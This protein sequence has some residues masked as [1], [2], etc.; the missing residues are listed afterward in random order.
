MSGISGCKN[1]GP[2]GPVGGAFELGQSLSVGRGRDA[3]IFGNSTG[4]TFFAVVVNSGLD[5]V[6]QA[7]FTLRASGIRAPDIPPLDRIPLPAEEGRAVPLRPDRAFESRLRDVERA[8][9]T[10]RFAAT[11]QWNATRVPALP[12][13]V[14]IGDLVTVNVNATDPCANPQYHTARVVAIGAKA[15]ILNDTLNPKP[16]F[17]T[18]DFQRYAAKFDTLVYP[19]DVDAFGEPTDI[20]KNGH[21]AIV[22]TRSV[23]E[24]TPRGAFS[25][26]GGLTFSRDLFPQVGTARAQACPSSNEGEYLYL[27]APDPNGTINGN[28]RTNGFVDTNT[29]AVIAHELVHL[30]NASRKLYVNTAAPKFEV[31]WLDEGLA[32]IAEELLFYRESGLTSRSNLTYFNLAETPRTRSAY[33]A[34]MAANTGRYRE[35][36]AATSTSSPYRAGDDL[37]TRGA[38]WSFL[39]YLADRR[40][41]SDGD[42][43]SRLVNNSAIGTANLQSVFG[44]DVASLVRDWSAS[45]A[46]DD[47]QGVAAELQQKSWNWRSIFGGVTASP[48]LYPLS[49]THMAASTPSYAGS[50]VPGGSAFFDFTVAANDTAT[51]TLDGQAGAPASNLQLVIVRTQ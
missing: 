18:T 40:A 51:F 37:S 41:A 10:P 39:R 42:V 21:I 22:F 49:V 48:A 28:R 50:V 36:L 24:L 17:S 8:T 14:A 38:A 25:F 27:M 2:V 1:D 12:T 47:V 13:T 45:Q 7:G 43:F 19:M 29:T 35:Y 23:N 5:S 15:L 26:V 11:R 32:H 33:Q 6:G 34:D 4:G 20:D 31:K 9:L 44:T 16:G 46:V 3:R 30:I